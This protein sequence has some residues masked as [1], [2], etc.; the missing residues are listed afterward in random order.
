MNAPI[1]TEFTPALSLF[2]GIIIGLSAI[3][4][5]YATGRIAGVSGILARVLPPKSSLQADRT[6]K[7]TSFGFIAGL[8]LAAPLYALST[9]AMPVQTVPSNTTL[10]VVAGGLV[11]FG[12]VYGN[13][14]TSGHGVCGL[15][16]LSQRSLVEIGRAHV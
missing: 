2:G 11:G 12:A 6:G 9:G 5:F 7:L 10:L 13:G 4:F 1:P 8:L 15:G 3:W 16:R 14:C